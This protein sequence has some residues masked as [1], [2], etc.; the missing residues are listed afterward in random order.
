MSMLLLDD[1][2]QFN[3]IN[4]H[5]ISV[6]IIN[7]HESRYQYKYMLHSLLSFLTIHFIVQLY[8]M[9]SFEMIS[10]Q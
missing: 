9:F 8:D 7:L 3:V 4:P 10:K 5:P 2:S 6:D 1:S